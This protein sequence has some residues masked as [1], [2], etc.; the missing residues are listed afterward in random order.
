MLSYTPKNKYSFFVY[1]NGQLEADLAGIADDRTFTQTRNDADQISFSLNND[2]LNDYCKKLNINPASLLQ[3]GRTEIRVVRN[4][5]PLVAGELGPWSGQVA[6]PRKI[7]LQ[8]YGWL[9]LF[10]QRLTTSSFSSTSGLSIA[11]NLINTTLALP[12]GSAGNFS[13]LTVGNVPSPDQTTIYGT[14]SPL[15]YNQQTIY[16]A[17]TNLANDINGFD[18]EVTWDKK[19]NFYW[20]HIGATRNDILFTYPGNITDYQPSIDPTGMYNEIL[21]TGSGS[22]SGQLQVTLDNAAS[23]QIYGLRQNALDDPNITDINLLENL[24]QAQ[25]NIYSQPLLIQTV[26]FD[27]S[28]RTSAPEVGS[29]HV[30]DLVK[31]FITNDGLYP[32]VNTYYMIDQIQVTINPDD[33]ETVTITIADPNLAANGDA[34]L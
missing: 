29:F 8:C 21:A 17:L 23:Q 5:I 19:I 31:V 3:A 18:I 9:D 2:K 27:G 22:G 14:G 7:N 15:T 34:T 30:G 33:T 32:A 20:P 28:G 11:Q 1:I 13:G 4:D 26:V 16:T 25:L 10:K 6:S 24:A 12:Y